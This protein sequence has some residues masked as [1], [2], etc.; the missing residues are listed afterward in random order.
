MAKTGAG[1]DAI[2]HARITE[3]VASTGASVVG[4]RLHRIRVGMGL[5]IRDVAA[6]ARVSKTS[7]VRLEQGGSCRATTVAAV[8]EVLGLHIERLAD[9][10]TSQSGA[11]HRIGDDRWHDMAD[12]AA[13]PI[14]GSGHDAEAHLPKRSAI[15][16]AVDLLRSRLPNGRVLPTILEVR[17]ESIARSHPGEEFVY[18]LAGGLRLTVGSDVFELKT[19]ESICFWSGE[20]HRYA[21]LG[22]GAARILSIRVD[23]YEPHA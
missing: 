16:V 20:P 7:I 6:R 13:G 4:D 10:A 21:P 9:G 5:S 3:L 1:Q 22:R 11:V 17:S 2:R 19:G 8:C 12:V 14:P 18:V 23:G 15:A